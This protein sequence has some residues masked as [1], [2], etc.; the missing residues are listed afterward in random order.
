MLL[1]RPVGA[2]VLEGLQN[3]KL[4]DVVAAFPQ[5]SRIVDFIK[6][7]VRAI[8]IDYNENPAMTLSSIIDELAEDFLL[9]QVGSFIASRDIYSSLLT[10]WN[11]TGTS[12]ALLVPHAPGEDVVGVHAIRFKVDLQS[13]T[14]ERI[15]IGGE[16]GLYFTGLMIVER[17]FARLLKERKNVPEAIAL[18][19]SGRSRGFHVWTGQFSSVNTPFNLLEATKDLLN[20]I[21]DTRVHVKAKISP[22]A[23]IEGPVIIEEHAVVDHYSVIKGPAYIGRGALVGAHSF[24]RQHVTI[25]SNAVVGASSEVKRSYV[26]PSSFISSHCYIT[27][28]VIGDR[29]MIRPFVVTLNY[30]PQEA[31]G[32]RM[33][34]KKGSIIGEKSIVNGG[35]ILKPKSVVKP[36]EVYQL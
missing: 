31:I 28:S 24:I 5:A 25:E 19:F 13:K 20:T 30:D 10:K 35:S 26:G 11:E 27:D 18:Y 1:G 34:A 22:T 7:P 6:P 17:D 23:V 36:R 29:A 4:K 14:I 9:L 2:F 32:S 12:L 3:A 15:E 8:P 16:K 33:L 21:Q